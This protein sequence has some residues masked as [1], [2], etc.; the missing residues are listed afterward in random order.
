MGVIGAGIGCPL[1]P[2]SSSPQEPHGAVV[3]GLPVCFCTFISSWVLTSTPHPPLLHAMPCTCQM[4][5]QDIR[6]EAAVLSV[7]PQASLAQL[8]L[9]ISLS[10]PFFSWL[11]RAG[12]FCGSPVPS[13]V[14]C[15]LHIHP[16]AA[17][18]VP[19]SVTDLSFCPKERLV[20]ATHMKLELHHTTL[21]KS[22]TN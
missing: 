20:T 1:M 9:C 17:A 22:T 2:S 21:N 13:P 19:K 4:L 6:N 16:C 5:F 14:T 11:H 12:C 3:I 7:N 15:L 10:V 18:Q 8:Q